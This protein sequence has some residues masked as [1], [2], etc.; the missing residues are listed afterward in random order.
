MNE[1]IAKKLGEVLAFTRVGNDTTLKGRAALIE[2]LGEEKVSDVEDK[3]RIHGEECIRLATDG[4]MIDT[5]LA[6]ATKTE[7]KLKQMRDLYV[8]DQWD[9]TTELMEWSG[10]FE[11]A[12]VVHFALIR[13]AGEGSNNQAL[14]LLAE[15]GIATHYELLELAETELA[16]VGQDR[17]AVE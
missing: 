9:N 8:G 12:A 14:S 16:Q 7:E 10:F 17:S 5:T 2:A 11:G 3:N 4:G 6:K 13:G 15:E 1:F